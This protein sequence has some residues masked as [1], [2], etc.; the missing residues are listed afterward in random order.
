MG[1]RSIHV[2]CVGEEELATKSGAKANDRRG[3]PV[4]RCP[5]GGGG[6]QNGLINVNASDFNPK[7]CQ[8]KG[9]ARPLET[10][11]PNRFRSPQSRPANPA[12][13]PGKSHGPAITRT[14]PSA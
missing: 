2:C 1:T 6:R 10:G 9:G 4:L 5:S 11:S 7:R 8:K 13:S 3:S 14:G 12:E